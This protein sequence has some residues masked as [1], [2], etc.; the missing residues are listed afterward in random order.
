LSIFAVLAGLA[1]LWMLIG[2]AV[3]LVRATAAEKRAHGLAARLA[4]VEAQLAAV[5]ASRTPDPLPGTAA[6]PLQPDGGAAAPIAAASPEAPFF[7]DAE[8]AAPANTSAPWAPEPAPAAPLASSEP[9]GESLE[10]R[11][12]GRWSVLVGGLALALGAIFL[13]RYSIEQ[14]LL[15]PGMRIALGFLLAAVLLAAGEALRRRDRALDFPALAKADVPAILSGAG[16]IA[17]FATIYAA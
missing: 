6:A 7:A 9:P 16:A 13:V 5:L 15:G 10:G 17:A 14:G 2:P 4:A 1:V 11:I 12:G 3:A 8:P